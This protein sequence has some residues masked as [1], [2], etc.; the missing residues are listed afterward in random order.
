MPALP[1]AGPRALGAPR[2]QGHMTHASNAAAAERRTIFLIG[3]V[4]FINVLDFVMVMPMGPDFATALHIDMAHLG[5]IGGAYT[6]AAA[7]SGVISSVFLDRFDRRAAL[8]LAMLGLSLGTI[9]GG[10]AWNLPTL[11][12]ARVLA[13]SFGG[14]ATALAMSIV[15]DAVPAERRGRAMGAV[16][17]AFS[18]ASVVGVPIGLELARRGGWRLPF[19]AIGGLGLLFN[20][21]VFAWL[22]QMRGHLQAA[23][24]RPIEWL[25]A[26]A[27]FGRREFRVCYVMAVV[28]MASGF[29]II[30]NLSGYCQ[31]NMGLPRADLGQLYLWGGAASFFSMRLTG[32]AVD[33]FGAVGTVSLATVIFVGILW[34]GIWN[35]HGWPSAIV[36]FVPF[37][38][39]NSTRFVSFNAVTS[40]VP[41][42]AE[43]AKFMASLSAVQHM[44]AAVGATASG[45][46]LT[47]LPD[48]KLQGMG[49]VALFAAGLAVLQPLLVAL[50]E[51]QVRAANAPSGSEQP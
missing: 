47:E 8:G 36:V 15:T 28:A 29:A 21:L 13:G 50:V 9:A 34:F 31:F 48:H 39:A 43:R 18:V 10:L 30:P 1:P 45:A 27:V 20:A 4:Q 12:L 42:P 46:M 7:V 3:A 22:P 38:I 19:F 5:A 49:N 40:K 35:W 44:A 11:L 32:R 33:R 24:A 14:P 41:K 26:V 6:A 16:A 51:R 23:L 2:I 17:G 25:Q 37:F